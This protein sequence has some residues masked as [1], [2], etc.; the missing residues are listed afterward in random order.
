MSNFSDRPQLQPWRAL[1]LFKVFGITAFIFVLISVALFGIPAF[2]AMANTPGQVSVEIIAAYNLVVDSNVLAPSTYAPAVATVGGK[3]C[4]TSSTEP[5]TGLQ[6]FIGNY[7]GGVGS[8]PGIYPARNSV[9]DPAFSDPNQYQYLY[10]TG[11]YAFQHVGGKMGTG[12]GA[13]YVGTLAPGQCQVQYWHFTYP[14]RSNG[15]SPTYIPNT[16]N[17]PTWGQTRLTGDDLALG[18]DVWANAPG[19]VVASKHQTMTMR[20]EISAMANKIKP[21]PDG[22]WFNTTNPVTAGTLITTNGIL[23]ELGVINQGFDNDGDYT[24]DF[25]AWVQPIGDPAYDPTASASFAP[26]V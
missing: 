18:F 7:N 26:A 6:V 21:N 25:N 8:T 15:P 23:Y 1:R 11:S 20:N 19:G 14:R 5:V 16:G 13:R 22:Q 12:D 2:R 3:V 24:P 4:N 17:Q 9:T 10:D